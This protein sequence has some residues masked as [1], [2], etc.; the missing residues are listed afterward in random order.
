MTDIMH[1]LLMQ[2]S[3]WRCNGKRYLSNGLSSDPAPR[4]S[5]PATATSDLIANGPNISR[6]DSL[7]TSTRLRLCLRP[8]HVCSCNSS[9]VRNALV[10]IQC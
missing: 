3:R 5:A 8:F 6:N 1:I 7:L 9:L 2:I 10:L 4:K